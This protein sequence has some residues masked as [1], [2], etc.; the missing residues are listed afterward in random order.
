ITSGR[1]SS[2]RYEGAPMKLPIR[3][4]LLAVSL[5]SAA[6]L[7]L[8]TSPTVQA[9]STADQAMVQAPRLASLPAEL[10]RRAVDVLEERRDLIDSPWVDASFRDAVV[11]M[12]RPGES[13]PAYVE[14][15]VEGP[16]G[17]PRGFMV[18]STGE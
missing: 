12:F 14:L 8:L 13:A 1:A 18:L 17:Q 7:A 4:F 3:S 16:D 10:H 6:G 9:A 2:L 11:P 5:P 15:T